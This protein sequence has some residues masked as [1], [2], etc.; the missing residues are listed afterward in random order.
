M[1]RLTIPD[2]SV[3]GRLTVVRPAGLKLYGGW[4]RTF[5][6]CR[7]ECGKIVQVLGSVLVSRHTNSCGC[8]LRE[9]R[10]VNA[11]THGM[12]NS[13]EY[14]AW[15]AMR[16]RCGNP[17]NPA[18]STY[19]GR[20]ISVCEEWRDS[21]EAFYASMGPKPS[22][23]HSLDRI[24]PNGDYTPA[25]CQWATWDIQATNKR[26]YQITADVLVKFTAKAVLLEKY[27]ARYGLLEDNAI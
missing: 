8:L 5:F 11:K 1:P 24:D 2:G 6:E 10:A 19:G 25:N 17:N 12:T 16:A 9:T 7:C 22:N 21:F 26:P 14:T 15:K 18:Y 20:G 13:P 27:Q 4:N 3:F 23:K